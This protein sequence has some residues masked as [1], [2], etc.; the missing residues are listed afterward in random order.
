MPDITFNVNGNP[1]TIDAEDDDA[2]LSLLRDRLGITGPRYGC[3]VGVCGACTIFQDGD[4]VRPC[5]VPM[6]DIGGSDLT[7]IEGIAL[8]D[9][10]HRLQQAWIDETSPSAATARPARS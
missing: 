4:A 9:V 1:V 3:G 10:L 2:L 5:V 8:D 7:T 6:E